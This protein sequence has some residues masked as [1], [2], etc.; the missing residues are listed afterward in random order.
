[1]TLCSTDGTVNAAALTGTEETQG[2]AA[3]FT[4][5]FIMRNQKGFTLIELVVVIAILGIL[6]AFALP[7]FANLT[8]QAR[9][10]A[11]NGLVGSLNSAAALAH[12]QW[13][14]NGSS[15]A[16]VNLDGQAVTLINGYPTAD[17]A[18]IDVAL[19]SLTG[20]T[21]SAGV[22]GPPATRLYDFPTAVVGCQATY[23]AAA[24][25]GSASASAATGSC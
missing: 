10:A 2:A 14:A 21:P 11:M 23:T 8:S 3:P 17:A 20:F 16:S 22:A 12:A 15:G 9:K 25:G 18:G 13:L 24:V 7:R 19:S 5:D 6:A 1:M 4:G